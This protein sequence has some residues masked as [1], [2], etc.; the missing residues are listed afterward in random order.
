MHLKLM[1]ARVYVVPAACVYLLR[2]PCARV[3]VAVVGHHLVLL[4]LMALG[5][6]AASGPSVRRVVGYR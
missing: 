4:A 1:E 2:L 5:L 6:L 3:A